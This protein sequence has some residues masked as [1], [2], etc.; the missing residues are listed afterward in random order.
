MIENSHNFALH[1]E[2][3]TLLP[4][5]AVYFGKHKTV[6]AADLH[7]GKSTHFRKEGIA[8]PA[9]LAEADLKNLSTIIDELNPKRLIILG[10]LFHAEANYDLELFKKWREN[11]RRL[12]IDLVKGNHDILP[13]DQYHEL[14][15]VTHDKHYIFSEFLLTHS[16]DNKPNRTKDF[17]YVIC[18]HVHPAVKLYGKGKQSET[19]PCFYFGKDYGLLPAFGG[20]TGRAIVHPVEKDNVFVIIQSGGIGKVLPA[21]SRQAN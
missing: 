19:L 1:G 9:V 11:N 18:A 16:P 17:K 10:D 3:L 5:K 8:V 15:I 4:Q 20:F 21:C 6:L 7:L 14:D 12:R 13:D 2:E